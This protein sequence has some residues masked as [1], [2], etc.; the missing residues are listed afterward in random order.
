MYDERPGGKKM[1][2]L[3]PDGNVL[4]RHEYERNR[5]KYDSIMRSHNDTNAASSRGS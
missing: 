3:K 5:R 4:R 1:P 2:M